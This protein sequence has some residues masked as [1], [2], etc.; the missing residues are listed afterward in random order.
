LDPLCTSV[1]KSVKTTTKFPQALPLLNG[2]S[3]LQSTCEKVVGI[4]HDMKGKKESDG[5]YQF[6]LD[7]GHP[8]KK[9]LNDVN[10]NCVNGLLVI[11]I[12]PRDQVNN[13]LESNPVSGVFLI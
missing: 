9:F 2:V 6:N 5:D 12:I 3:D 8:Y 1:S 4:V 11:E 13:P 10:N 7:L